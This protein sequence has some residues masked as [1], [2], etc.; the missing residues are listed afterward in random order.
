MLNIP[1]C[2]LHDYDHKFPVIKF[3]IFV[4]RIKKIISRHC[5]TSLNEKKQSE[6]TLP[7]NNFNTNSS[8]NV[9]NLRIKFT[10]MRF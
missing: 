7:Q 10:N 5:T 9:H 1:C 6:Y 2:F 3:A 8:R 4:E